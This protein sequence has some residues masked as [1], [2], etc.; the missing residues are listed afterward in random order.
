[1]S[2]PSGRES[3]DRPGPEGSPGPEPSERE[4]RAAMLRLAAD[5]G[6]LAL[7][8]V[9]VALTGGADS[10]CAVLFVLPVVHA[11]LHQSSERLLPLCVLALGLVALPVAYESLSG[12]EAAHLAAPALAIVLATA[13]AHSVVVRMGARIARLAA[14]ESAALRLADQ[15]PLTGLGN[16]RLFWRQAH[17]EAARVRRHGGAFSIV[18]VDLDAF[19]SINDRLGHRAGDA[20]LQRV[21]AALQ[22]AVRTED[23]LC[24]HGGD[25]FAVVAVEASEEEADRLAARLAHAV[26]TTSVADGETLAASIGHASFTN[27]GESLDDV[28][29]LA[30]ERLRQSKRSRWRPPLARALDETVAAIPPESR[31]AAPP[32]EAATAG[33]RAGAPARE[34]V[35]HGRLAV[36][37]GLARAL[38]AA[39][40]ERT[41]LETSVAHTAG[42]I[43]A[44]V[45][46]ALRLNRD[47]NLLEL[48]AYA[49]VTGPDGQSRPA[50][51][52]VFAEVVGREHPVV[53][54]DLPT[55]PRYV[56]EAH[57]P[58]ARSVLVAPVFSEGAVWG[59]LA[60]ESERPQLFV[61]QELDLVQGVTAQLGRALAYARVH[62]RLARA[63]PGDLHQL[64]AAVQ[65]PGDRTWSVAELTWRVGRELGLQPTELRA[66]YL[67]ALFHD[68]GTLG[69]PMDVLLKRGRLAPEERDVVHQHPVIGERLLRALP[70]L[71]E[72]AG[73]V[74]HEHERWD[75]EGY[76]DGLRGEAIPLGSRLLLACDA[77]VAMRTARPYRPPRSHEEAVIELRRASGSQ[78]D[79][80]VV[81]ALLAVL[82]RDP[83]LLS[84]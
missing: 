30:D 54:H 14:A 40:D 41:A 83:E 64:A 79:P 45:V 23:V 65:E 34:E 10:P 56:P 66:A 7:V 73:L 67:A 69:I 13:V 1:M 57:S 48:G 15:D 31:P 77:Y 21:G 46:A 72:S 78:L 17:A 62:P 29:L 82:E 84:A 19:K 33:Q 5:A 37:T 74:R 63:T 76:P 2:L 27:R 28:V 42:A 44:D 39:R 43:D 35:D 71:R 6:G 11:A 32:P 49:G 16:Y 51:R 20:A 68:I 75:G 47:R 9:L 36:L 80:V 38:A 26:A 24:R 52:G 25:E 55:D 53:V 3:D 70:P 22:R 8:A 18:L 50:D 59:V 12:R 81:N 58:G 61:G 4:R 60:A